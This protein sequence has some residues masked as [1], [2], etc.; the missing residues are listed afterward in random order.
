MEEQHPDWTI[1]GLKV[2]RVEHRILLAN[3]LSEGAHPD[4][5]PQF[6]PYYQ[7]DYDR[8]GRIKDEA[9][10]YLFWLLPIEKVKPE[11]GGKEG[12]VNYLKKQSGDE[13]AKE[14]LPPF[15]GEWN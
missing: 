15:K 14:P 11:G 5:A 1:T 13:D 7:G 4:D 9:D 8:D 10:R 6:F 3:Q 12:L 2:Y